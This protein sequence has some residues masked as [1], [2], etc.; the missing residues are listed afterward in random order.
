VADGRVKWVREK[1]Y[2]EVG[3]GGELLVGF[4]ITQD[5]TARKQIEESLAAAKAA[6]EAA[7]VAKSQFLANMSHE[8]RT[9]MNAILGMIDVA[10]PLAVVDY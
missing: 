3:P 2:L 1:A 10:L 8:P 9:P 6:A 7:T 4:G 5:I